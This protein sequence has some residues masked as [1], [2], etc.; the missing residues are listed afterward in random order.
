MIR[1]CTKYSTTLMRGGNNDDEFAGKAV[2]CKVGGRKVRYVVVGRSR[3]YLKGLYHLLKY[4]G[5]SSRNG[6]SKGASHNLSSLFSRLWM[7]QSFGTE[8][9]VTR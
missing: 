9:L 8:H 6:W 2:L 3:T 7:S 5:V 1:K 4:A